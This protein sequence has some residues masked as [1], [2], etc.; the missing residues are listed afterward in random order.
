MAP[1]MI[2]AVRGMQPFPAGKR[3]AMQGTE[4]VDSELSHVGQVGSG[5]KWM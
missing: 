4:N 3:Q 2:C 1:K 5:C